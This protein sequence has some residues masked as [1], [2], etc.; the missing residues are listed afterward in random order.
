[1]LSKVFRSYKRAKLFAESNHGRI[2]EV[3][4]KYVVWYKLS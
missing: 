1:M 2:Q 3:N 4:D